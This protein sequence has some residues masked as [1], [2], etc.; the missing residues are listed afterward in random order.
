MTMLTDYGLAALAAAWG[1]LLLRVARKGGGKSVRLWAWGFLVSSAAAFTGG[2][3]HGF[4]LAFSGQA[5]H[6]VW[7]ATVFL[8][9]AASALM[10]GG[11]WVASPARDE[12]STRWLIV[13]LVA[14]LVGLVIEL[15]GLDL[16]QNFNHN[17][18]YHV[19]QMVALYLFYRGARLLK[20]H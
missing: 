10:V 2:T 11:T 3:F 4:R 15:C 18:L 12:E 20:D 1:G 16:H 13:G 9:G 5:Q 6:T 8:I 7:S 14:S 19:V 17:D